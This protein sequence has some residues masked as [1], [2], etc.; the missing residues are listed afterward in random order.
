MKKYHHFRN[1]FSYISFVVLFIACSS[2][3]ATSSSTDND[4]NS[5]LG[6]DADFTF[7]SSGGEAPYD[8]TFVSTSSGQIDT[9]EWN[10]DNNAGAESFGTSF[11]H[12]Y[13]Q[14]GTFDVMLT[15]VGPGGQSTLIEQNAI[16]I[17]EPDSESFT[18]FSTGNANID[19][20]P[21]GGFCLMGGAAE[22]DNAM[23]WF[24]N[25]ADGG[26]IVV[27]RTSGSDG[28]N[29]Y[30]YQDLGVTINSVNSIVFQE[31]SEDDEIINL[32]NNAE[33]LWFAGGD[34][35]TYIDYWRDTAIQVAIKNAINRGAVMGGTSAG[36]AIFGDNVWTGSVLTEDFLDI[37]LFNGIIFD[38]HFSER[39]REQRLKDFINQSSCTIGIGADEN[40]AI[41]FENDGSF[42][43]YAYSN[44]KKISFID[45]SENVETVDGD[46]D[47]N[48]PFTVEDILSNPS[49]ETGLFSETMTYDS[50]TREYLIYIPSSYDINQPT[51]IVFAFHGFGGDNQYFINTADF[52]YL[53]DQYNFIVVYPQALVCNGGTT[54][55]TAPPG[56][57]N[58]CSQ[59][60]IGFFGALLYEISGNYNVDSEKVYLT[61][62]SNGAGFS[63]AMACYQ[64]SLVTAVAPVSGLMPMNDSSECSPSH[65]T[66]VILFNGTNDDSRPYDGIE[67]YMMSVDETV[68][69]WSGY[70]NTDSNPNVTT[71]G[72]I[73]NSSY[74]NGDS[75]SAVDLFKING[76]GHDWF[77]LDFNGSN[78]E[79][80]IWYF[81]SQHTSD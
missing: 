49:T 56:G 8:I 75:N 6:P 77:S 18:I 59:D 50:E 24:L 80:L 13:N 68:T 67:G 48:G 55:N 38:T 26:D 14:A 73:E 4:D 39:D 51:P 60:D 35:A 57:D 78:L 43:V 29:D 15:V 10:V 70:N 41:T 61:G 12:T 52:R 44:E 79:E 7:S 65:P 47:G 53:A 34:Q 20:S 23:I 58:K 1:L 63:Y 37:D 32:I 5:L 22:D 11:T 45:E 66:S 25:R 71:V 3:S 69:Y 36:M 46:P 17:T 54:W 74:R 33:G 27:L 21:Q 76:G 19:T 64:S 40:T 81:L 62:Y 42:H 16:T 28:Y 30:M 9:Y 2:D 31:Q 72:N